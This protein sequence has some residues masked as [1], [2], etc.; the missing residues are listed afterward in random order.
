MSILPLTLVT[1]TRFQIPGLDPWHAD[2]HDPALTVMTDFRERASVTVPDT[3]L[4][5]EALEHM[6]HTGVRCAFAIDDRKSIVVGLITAYDITGER[7][8]QF[9]QSEAIPRREVLVRDIMREISE[10]P[11]ADIKQIERA[12]V[13]AVSN[14][15]AKT[16]FSHVPVVETS[17]AGEQRLRG[18]LSAAKVKRLLS[19]PE[20]LGVSAT[21]AEIS[22]EDDTCGNVKTDIATDRPD[23]TNSSQV[24]PRASVQVENG[25]N[26]TDRQGVTVIDGSNT[27]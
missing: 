5:D 23:V 15:F 18:L 13:A 14:M 3:A 10:C 8:M 16:Q 6:R 24:V 27:R 1:N 21:R 25:I 9:M 12:T 20:S 22:D 7:P 2:P 17:D 11:V 26:W 19:G 4:I